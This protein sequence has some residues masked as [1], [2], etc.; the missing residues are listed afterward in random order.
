MAFNDRKQREIALNEYGASQS[1]TDRAIGWAI[2]F[3]TFFLEAE[4]GENKPATAIGHQ[5]LSNL[6]EE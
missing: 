3:G 4:L 2:F 5:I 6:N 1:L